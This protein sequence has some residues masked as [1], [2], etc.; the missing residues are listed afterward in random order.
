LIVSAC[1]DKTV[2][3]WDRL[4]KIQRANWEHGT[5]VRAVACTPPTASENWC[6][7]GADDGVPRLYN[8]ETLEPAWKDGERPNAEF[9]GRHAGQITSVAFAPNGRFC[10]TA[11]NKDIFIWDVT[12]GDLKY[13]F[14]P[15]HKRSEERRVGKEWR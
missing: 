2:R 1:E 15:L 13:K 9:K 5:A 3:V 12:T 14:P 8:L 7:T 11:D 10:A 6:L 4:T